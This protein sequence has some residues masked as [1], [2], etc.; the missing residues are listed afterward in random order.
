MVKSCTWELNPG[1]KKRTDRKIGEVF[2][3]EAMEEVKSRVVDKLTSESLEAEL[4]KMVRFQF[5]L[6]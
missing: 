1:C 6:K 5:L 2:T 3:P 4:R